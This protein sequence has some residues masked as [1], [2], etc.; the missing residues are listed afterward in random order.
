MVDREESAALLQSELDRA[1][2]CQE[3]RGVEYQRILHRLSREHTC[4]RDADSLQRAF[5][6]EMAARS[7]MWKALQRLTEFE[8]SGAIPQDLDV[9][10]KPARAA[11][12]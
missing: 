1:I 9:S 10:P 5:L 6:A 11:H 2:L 4:S 8:Q 7:A 3:Q 12:G